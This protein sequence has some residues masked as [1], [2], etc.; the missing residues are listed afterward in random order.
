MNTP[1]PFQNNT[2]EV[3][4]H[5]A[6]ARTYAHRQ[7]FVA[8]ISGP[9]TCLMIAQQEQ[10]WQPPP[11]LHSGV[12]VGDVRSDD[13]MIPEPPLTA[14]LLVNLCARSNRDEFAVG[15][16]RERFTRHC[17]ERGASRARAL[18]WSD[19]AGYLLRYAFKMATLVAAIKRLLGW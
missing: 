2:D 4:C 11:F 17:I 5:I 19:A 13:S 6:V 9:S 12:I 18:Y 7:K 1:L 16:M 3:A 15:D 8:A 14:E 10:P